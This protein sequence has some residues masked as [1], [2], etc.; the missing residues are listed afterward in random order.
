MP[1]PWATKADFVPRHHHPAMPRL[2]ADLEHLV[3]FLQIGFAHSRIA[4]GLVG[5]RPR[6]GRGWKSSSLKT[7]YSA[8]E[9]SFCA[10]TT[11]SRSQN[12]K[13]GRLAPLDDDLAD[14]LAA[15]GQ[16]DA[17]HGKQSQRK[18]ILHVST[19]RAEPKSVPAEPDQSDKRLY[20]VHASRSIIISPGVPCQII[21]RGTSEQI[22]DRGPL[23]LRRRPA[24]Q[25]IVKERIARTF[26]R[27]TRRTNG[28]PRPDT[29]G[30][31]RVERAHVAAG[32]GVFD[33][34]DVVADRCLRG[35]SAADFRQ[36]GLV[37]VPDPGG[38]DLGRRVQRFMH[39]GAGGF[40]RRP[41]E[42]ERPAA[43]NAAVS[44]D[45]HQRRGQR[46]LAIGVQA[47]QARRP[48]AEAS[49]NGSSRTWPG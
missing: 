49:G 11:T 28:Q 44:R 34:V 1:A 10:I 48:I 29:A 18:R 13:A 16:R 5:Q 26:P 39:T 30:V 14:V 27:S 4:A 17:R 31:R 21:F 15:V 12:R 3:A 40:R 35:Q 9:T 25:Q 33:Q 43:Q 41:S 42:I 23:S 47:R 8:F 45:P 46:Q 36:L 24:G 20:T 6:L 32:P 19:Q 38:R 37:G 22:D 7:R 2:P